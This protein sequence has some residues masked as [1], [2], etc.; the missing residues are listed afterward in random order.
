M[1]R[2]SR[3]P[4]PTHL[5][6][7]DVTTTTTPRNVSTTL[8]R[9][10]GTTT[11]TAS[12]QQQQDY[13]ALARCQT[14]SSLAPTQQH[15][16]IYKDIS[17]TTLPRTHQRNNHLTAMEQGSLSSSVAAED[18]EDQAFRALVR[19]QTLPSLAPMQTTR[20]YEHIY[21][22]YRNKSA[23]CRHHGVK[24]Q[25]I[26]DPSLLFDG[27]KEPKK[28]SAFL[29]CDAENRQPQIL[30]P[31]LPFDGAKHH[32]VCNPFLPLH[33]GDKHEKCSTSPPPFFRRL[34]YAAPATFTSVVQDENTVD[35]AEENTSDSAIG[36]TPIT[37][38]NATIA[39]RNTTR[40]A[41][42]NTT[43]TGW[44]LSRIQS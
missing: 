9:I 16:R 6:L 38:R 29:S 41:S 13:Q 27:S 36:N 14:L 3:R 40:T 43:T 42:R 22:S 4:R 24:R 5:S 31:Y 12:M 15:T 8:P 10:R 19:C 18:E 28:C 30:N 17:S 20:Q 37:S 11:T 35:T 32:Q 23:D 21:S 39:T 1:T 25:Q 7:E 2:K 44:C 26:Y 34:C 33:G